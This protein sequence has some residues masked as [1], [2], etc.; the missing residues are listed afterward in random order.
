VTVSGSTIT[1]TGSAA[2][3]NAGAYT[4]TGGTPPPANLSGTGNALSNV[5]T[6]NGG[7]NILDGAGGSD[8]LVGGLGNDTYLFSS[9]YGANTIIDSAGSD[10]LA[11]G[12]GI[13]YD[14]LWF[15]QNGN[16]LD[17]SVIGTSDK[18]TIQD[19]YLGSA[20]HVENILSG[21]GKALQDTQVQNLVQAMAAFAPPSAGQTTL[22][23]AYQTALAPVLAANWH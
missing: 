3:T 4:L 12:T 6:G 2:W 5:I 1:K 21:D 9:G 19:W 13:N 10:K 11:L 16:N 20:N 7:D 17:V 8:T 15:A 14:Q 22:P 18:I 23:S